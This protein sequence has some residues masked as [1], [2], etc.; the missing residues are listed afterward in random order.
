[1][2]NFV[3]TISN[4]SIIIINVT[5]YRGYILLPFTGGGRGINFVCSDIYVHN[6]KKI[7]KTTHTHIIFYMTCKGSDSND[8]EKSM[9]TLYIQHICRGSEFLPRKL[10]IYHLYMWLLFVTEGIQKEDC[11]R[12]G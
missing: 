12:L 3:I 2:L 4:R 8:L 11:V 5:V 1:M 9:H 7:S 10:R 6:C